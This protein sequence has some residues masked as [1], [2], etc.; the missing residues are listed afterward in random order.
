MFSRKFSAHRVAAP[1]VAVTFRATSPNFGTCIPNGLIT[2]SAMATYKRRVAGAAANANA[3]ARELR[4]G[5][6]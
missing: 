1:S 6:F 4:G 5:H 2:R 3:P